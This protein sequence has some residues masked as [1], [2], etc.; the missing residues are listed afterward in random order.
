MKKL[1]LLL[2]A[3]LFF[4]CEDDLAVKPDGTDLQVAEIITEEANEEPVFL[5]VEDMPSFPG[6]TEAYYK[7]LGSNINYP[8][9]AKQKG[10]EGKVFITFIV[11]EDG[12]LSNLKLER[13]IGGGCDEEAL[14]VFMESPNWNPGKQRGRTV[15]T[16]M[17]AAVT[18]ELGNKGEAMLELQAPG[19]A[20]L[21]QIRE[22]APPPPPKIREVELEVQ[23]K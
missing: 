7:F 1:S 23:D 5:V 9:E 6:G 4:A 10:I 20:E 18:F 17:Q 3:T 8:T 13:G 11:N 2:L 21:P 15:K 19:G 14:R 22:I 12:S 16:K